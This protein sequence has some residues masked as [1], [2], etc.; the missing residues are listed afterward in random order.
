MHVERFERALARMKEA[1]RLKTVKY[2]LGY[3]NLT[4]ELW[5]VLHK[6]DCFAPLTHR[7]QYLPHINKA[8]GEKFEDLDHYK[9]EADFKRI[10]GKLT[11]DDV[12]DA[13][14]RSASLMAQKCANNCTEQN[15]KGYKFYTENPSLSVGQVVQKI[16]VE[17]GLLN[18]IP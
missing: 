9:R 8:F 10:L 12:R 5:I 16:L 17:C 18:K 2:A 14:K 13:V 7:G 1:A 3:S 11:L 15:C 4:F 6:S